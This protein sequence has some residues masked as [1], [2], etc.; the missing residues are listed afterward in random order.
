MTPII[1]LSTKI[2]VNFIRTV[3]CLVVF[4]TIVSQMGKQ[5]SQ[6]RNHR[7]INYNGSNANAQLINLLITKF[8][9]INH[10]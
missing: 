4:S 10:T 8:G 3:I 6:F 7:K 1:I 2:L 9:K 5:I